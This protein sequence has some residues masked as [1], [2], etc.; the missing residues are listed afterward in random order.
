MP[1]FVLMPAPVITTTFFAFHNACAISWSRDSE[2]AVTWVV[3][4]SYAWEAGEGRW[5]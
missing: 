2:S 1:E 3:G 4:I 5:A